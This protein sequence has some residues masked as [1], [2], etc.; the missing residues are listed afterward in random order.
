MSAMIGGASALTLATY[1]YPP[2][3]ALIA[4]WLGAWES[5]YRLSRRPPQ[6]SDDDK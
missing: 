4:V 3:A 2:S 6:D 5:F 1:L